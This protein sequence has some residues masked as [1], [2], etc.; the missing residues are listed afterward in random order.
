MV[1]THTHTNSKATSHMKVF[2]EFHRQPHNPTVHVGSK[3]QWLTQSLITQVKYDC[4]IQK[5]KVPDHSVEQC[6]L[7]ARVSDRMAFMLLLPACTYRG[8]HVN[9]GSLTANDST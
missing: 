3:L 7:T 4:M 2:A 6:S 9:D 5:Q 1:H 8:V